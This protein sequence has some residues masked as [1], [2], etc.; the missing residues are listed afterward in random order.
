M[1]KMKKVFLVLLSILSPY[2]IP[3]QNISEKLVKYYN[4]NS[5]W[6]TLRYDHFLKIGSYFF[7]ENNNRFNQEPGFG[8]SFPFKKFYQT[9]VWAGY[10]HKAHEKWYLGI[11]ERYIAVR[12]RDS[13]CTRINITH[14]GKLGKLAFTKEASLE[15]FKYKKSDNPYIIIE[16][17][18]MA[19]FAPALVKTF[20][21]K[22]RPLYVLLSYRASVLFDWNNDNF[23]SYDKR[24]IDFTRL[25]FEISH[26]LTQNLL[27]SLFAM[28]ETYYSYQLA[29][30]DI[31]NNEI[32]PEARVNRI[33]PVI[34]FS[35]NYVYKR[36]EEGFL[37]AFPGK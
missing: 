2:L 16:N 15:H 13:W 1:S 3:A 4:P 33:T 21:I 28:R 22:E 26:F 8:E 36:P 5:W 17:E 29:Q 12:N 25:R 31:N 34:G 32:S 19:S 35:L 11:S 18:G 20:S 7:L 37:P 10:E 24:N 30:Y 23:S 6:L 14:R 9:Y 27:V